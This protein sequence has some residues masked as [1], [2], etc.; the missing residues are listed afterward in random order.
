[1]LNILN[2]VLNTSNKVLNTTNNQSI[3][4]RV[5]KQS[6]INNAETFSYQDLSCLEIKQTFHII[7]NITVTFSLFEA[8]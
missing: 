4:E 2:K 5:H 7:P 3:F 6:E 8:A 1:M